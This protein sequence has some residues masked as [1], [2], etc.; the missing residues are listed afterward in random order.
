MR[1]TQSQRDETRRRIVMSARKLLSKRGFEATTTRDLASKAGIASGTFFNY[2]QTK[3]ALV[4]ALVTDALLQGESVFEDLQ[5]VGRSLD[6]Q[7]FTHV[8]TGLRSLKDHRTYLHPVIER[9]LSPFADARDGA[10]SFRA[11]HIETVGRLLHAAG[12]D[13]VDA[14]TLHLYWGLYIAVLAFW[15][16]D[17]SPHQEDTLALLDRSIKLFVLSLDSLPSLEKPHVA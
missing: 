12:H 6:E 14:A 8:A 7:L 13:N 11:L 10:H 4:T 2:F 3:E 1:V 16:R 17:D 9:S 15:T 5:S